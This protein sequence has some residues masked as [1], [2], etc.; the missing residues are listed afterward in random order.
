MVSTISVMPI[1]PI[2]IRKALLIVLLACGVPAAMAGESSQLPS[3]VI[4]ALDRFS[5]SSE[6]LSVRVENLASRKLVL[7]YQSDTARNPASTM[8]LVTTYAVLDELSPGYQWDTEFFA[9][10]EIDES[11][12]LD[13]DLAIRGGGDPYL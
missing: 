6:G 7:D 10:G 3:G 4:K 13:G 11:G 2:F 1:Q 5:L 9:L 8:K 12:V